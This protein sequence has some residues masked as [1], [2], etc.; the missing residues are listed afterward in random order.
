[1]DVDGFVSGHSAINLKSIK[2]NGRLM[3]A[4]D[5]IPPLFLLISRQVSLAPVLIPMTIIET[6]LGNRLI[7]MPLDI[8]IDYFNE[9]FHCW[10]SRCS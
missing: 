8:P 5:E 2:E 3:T 1:M 4:A 10:L 7:T 9:S 6:D